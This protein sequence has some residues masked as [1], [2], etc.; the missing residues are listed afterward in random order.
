MHHVG[1]FTDQS[2]NR[3]EATSIL[4]IAPTQI[5]PTFLLSLFV[6]HQEQKPIQEG[7]KRW[8][9]LLLETIEIPSYVFKSEKEPRH[10]FLLFTI[11][12]FLMHVKIN[13]ILKYHI[14]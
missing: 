9:K 4:Q 12:F 2:M 8:E 7:D 10:A 1:L 5:K 14:N 11:L 13:Q 3:A 6:F